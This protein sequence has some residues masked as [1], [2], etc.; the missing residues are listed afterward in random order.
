MGR[1][2]IQGM[3]AHPLSFACCLFSKTSY[4]FFVVFLA[5]FFGAAFFFAA[6]LVAI[7][8]SPFHATKMLRWMMYKFIALASQEKSEK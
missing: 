5:A 8:Y 4:F 3:L 7:F 6:F 2:K 1:T